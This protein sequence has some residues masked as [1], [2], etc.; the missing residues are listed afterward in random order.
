MK[1]TDVGEGYLAHRSPTSIHYS[2]NPHNQAIIN[3]PDLD[4][5]GEALSPARNNIIDW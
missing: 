1:L 2:S 5:Q 4:N 3:F